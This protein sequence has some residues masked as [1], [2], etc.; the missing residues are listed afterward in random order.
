MIRKYEDKDAGELLEAWYSGSQVG[1]PFLN[2][3][4]FELERE[5][6][7]ALYL[8]NAETWVFELEGVVVGFIALIGNEVGAIFVDS[9]FHRLGIGRQLMAHTE[10]STG[11]PAPVEDEYV[12]T[13]GRNYQKFLEGHC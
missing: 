4:F 8:P 7:L 1:H 6:I 10:P 13:T 12:A 2:P 5:N 11:G 3:D 9:K